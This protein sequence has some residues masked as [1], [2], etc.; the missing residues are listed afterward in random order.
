[1]G[2][3]SKGS[4]R[5]RNQLKFGSELRW[6]TVPVSSR[7]DTPIDEVEIAG[8]DWIA[9]HEGLLR[10]SLGRAPHF[11]DALRL[12]REGVGSGERRLSRLNERLTRAVC[13]YLGI[14]T[15]IV[16]AR[17]YGASGAKTRRLLDLL[18]KVGADAYLSGPTA[19]GYIDEGAFRDAGVRLEYKSY[20]YAPYAQ[21]GGPFEGAVSVL[22]LIANCGPD[23]ARSLRSRAADAVAVP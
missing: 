11:A 19:R 2:F 3:G 12:W 13:A 20:D 1:V 7:P 21:L 9:S 8:D 18:G 14:G 17:P 5:H 23:S 22:D 10:Q 15:R 16:Q 4:W 6:L